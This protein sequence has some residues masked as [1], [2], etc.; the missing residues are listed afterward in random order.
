MNEFHKKNKLDQVFL[1]IELEK[2]Y[3][4]TDYKGCYLIIYNYLF[5][6]LT[7]IFLLSLNKKG[8]DN[9]SKLDCFKLKMLF[10]SFMEKYDK[11]KRFIEMKP[12]VYLKNKQNTFENNKQ[13]LI[14]KIEEINYVMNKKTIKKFQIHEKY[15]LFYVNDGESFDE[16]QTMVDY[17]IYENLIIEAF[18]LRSNEVFLAINKF[19]NFINDNKI[20]SPLLN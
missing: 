17:E 9:I 7:K 18:K 12:E 3:L 10:H 14:K 16:K 2:K 19:F 15:A 6:L 20:V 5:Y 13:Y 11:F 4:L 1:N 8:Y